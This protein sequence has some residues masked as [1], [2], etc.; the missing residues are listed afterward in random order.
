MKTIPVKTIMELLYELSDYFDQYA[1]VDSGQ[2]NREMVYY[3]DIENLID[4]ILKTPSLK[5]SL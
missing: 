4:D 5:E 1:D 3:T 2:P